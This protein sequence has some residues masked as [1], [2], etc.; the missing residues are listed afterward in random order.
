MPKDFHPHFMATGIGSLPHTDPEQ[1]AAD[2]LSRLDQMPYWP[3]LPHR[4]A[5]EDM[6]LMFVRG[7][8]PLVAGDEATRALA[9]HPT[10][11]R[12]EALAGYYER[13][14]SPD[15]AQFKLAPQEAAGL[16]EFMAKVESAPAGSYP[17]LK[18]HVTGPITISGSVIGENGKALLYDDEAAEA[19][20]RGLGISAA[21][22]TEQLSVLGRPL[23]MFIDEPALSGFGSA[24]SPI[25][26]EKVIELLG[27]C[28]EELRSRFP[29]T[30]CGVHC[31]G[32]TD[33]AMLIESG[34]DVINLDSAG[35]GEHLLLYPEALEDLFARDG[36]VAWGAVPAGD[37]KGDET[38]EGLWNGLKALLENLEA[39]GIAKSTLANQALVTPACGLGTLNQAQARRILDLTAQVS[40]LAQENYS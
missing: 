15:L 3:Q 17:W 16:Y 18:G 32:N 6:N 33:W 31:C 9:A 28:L 13:I 25:A 4:A 12:E 26:R 37:F 39:K 21:A 8:E 23:M 10:C 5:L 36:A 27:A 38:A 11:S 30:V 22:Q 34:F 19:L 2:V 20:A 7:L 29:E 24:F 14:L 40:R 35:Y 1:A